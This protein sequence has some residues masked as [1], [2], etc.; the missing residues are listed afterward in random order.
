MH[1]AP[2]ALKLSVHEQA[3]FI[4]ID[5]TETANSRESLLYS[6]WTPVPVDTESTIFVPE[7]HYNLVSEL[8][9][10]TT[11]P[12]TVDSLYKNPPKDQAPSMDITRKDEFG[13]A[14]IHLNTISGEWRENLKNFRKTLS[15]DGISTIYLQVPADKPIPPDMDE[16][17]AEAGFFFSGII[18]E[19]LN[20][21]MLLYTF[22]NNQKFDFGNIKL[23][24]ESACALKDYIE[25]CYKEID[26]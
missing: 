1:F 14:K 5:K 17:L 26:L 23:F 21:W 18:P 25:K 4:D 11:I 6:I 15:I 8:V 2:L 24:D 20:K 16:R 13:L 9:E 3:E 10:K 12:V 19:R 22:F 7:K